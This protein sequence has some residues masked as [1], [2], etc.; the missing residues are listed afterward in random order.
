MISKQFYSILHPLTNMRFSTARLNLVKD[1]LSLDSV[2]L[3]KYFASF[4]SLFRVEYVSDLL[5]DFVSLFKYF[6]GLFFVW[7][8][9]GLA[10]VVGFGMEKKTT[11]KNKKKLGC[12]H[13]QWQPPWLDNERSGTYR[14]TNSVNIK[15]EEKEAVT[16]DTQFDMWS[17]S[18]QLV[19]KDI[20]K[21]KNKDRYIRLIHILA[22]FINVM[23]LSIFPPFIQT[24]H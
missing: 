20:S 3:V 8:W 17:Q 2:T 24:R 16:L 6:C 10:G 1:F 12:Y 22:Y 23:F 5:G 7:L 21:M 9:F 4:H 14:N 18:C 19:T 11:K 13:E 15:S